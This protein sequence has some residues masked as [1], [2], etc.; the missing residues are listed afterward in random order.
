M[1]DRGSSPAALSSKGSGTHEGSMKGRLAQHGPWRL[2][3]MVPM[4][5]VLTQD[6]DIDTDPNCSRTTDPDITMALVAGQVTQ[7]SWT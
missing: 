5:P 7:I 2:A 6:M 3:P 1:R 4:A